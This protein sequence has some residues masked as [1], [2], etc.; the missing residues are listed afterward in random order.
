MG[1]NKA[2]PFGPGIPEMARSP[3]AEAALRKAVQ[4]AAQGKPVIITGSRSSDIRRILGSLNGTLIT[5]PFLAS[6][7]RRFNLKRRPSRGRG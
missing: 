6:I 2:W 5:A 7:H 3:Q 4:V 1:D